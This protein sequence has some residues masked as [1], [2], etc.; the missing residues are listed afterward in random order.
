MHDAQRFIDI[1]LRRLN[2]RRIHVHAHI[3]NPKLLSLFAFLPRHARQKIRL[4][5]V[6][7]TLLLQEL[8][9]RRLR[10]F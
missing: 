8:E 10:R 7:H 9:I 2:H 6:L 4:Q 5:N 1:L 3:L